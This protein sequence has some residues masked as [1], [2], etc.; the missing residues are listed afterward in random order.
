MESASTIYSKIEADVLKREENQ[1]FEYEEEIKHKQKIKQFNKQIK[2][3][4]SKSVKTE[5]SLKKQKLIDEYNDF[6]YQSL[7]NDLN[8]RSN[9][10]YLYKQ[11]EYVNKN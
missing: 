11:L 1:K 3:T 4:K 10:D 6:E 2:K 9:L 5:L 7:L 8:I